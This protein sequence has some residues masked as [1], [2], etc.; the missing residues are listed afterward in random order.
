M[1]QSSVD[2]MAGLIDNVLDFA[3]G[4]LGGGL[5]IDRSDWEMAPILSQVIDE[6]RSASPDRVIETHFDIDRLVNCDRS[7]I[8]QLF[9]NLL[10]NALTHGARTG[11]VRVVATTEDG[12]FELSVANPGADIPPAALARLFHPFARGGDAAHAQGLGLGLY[13]AS[14]IAKA[15]SGTLGVESAGGETRFTFRMP[16]T[17]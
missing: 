10:G 5:T 14:E 16:L 2:R 8:A 6:L 9:S 7:K 17:S 11:P 12:W 4:R 13:I 1:M 3:R 15:H